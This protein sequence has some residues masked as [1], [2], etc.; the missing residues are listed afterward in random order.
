M[1]KRPKAAESEKTMSIMDHIAELRKRFVKSFLIFVIAMII[2]NVFYNPILDFVRHPLCISQINHCKLLL[3]SPLDGL[4]VRLKITSY[5]AI[6]LSFPF[7][8]YQILRFI[9]PGLT[10]N[11]KRYLFP[12]YA[13]VVIFFIMG[14]AVAYITY[15]HALTW[16]TDV[17][18]NNLYANYTADKYISLLLALMLIFGATFEFPVVLVGLELLRVISYTQLRKF[19]KYAFV[20]IVIAGGVLTPSSDPF[21]MF[22][23]VVPLYIFYELS[24]LAGR[25][26]VRPTKE[27]VSN[28]KSHK[29]QGMVNQSGNDDAESTD[30]NNKDSGISSAGTSINS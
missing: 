2:A 19:R 7:I 14:A 9:T 17:A 28:I 11:E 12:I 8:S 18:G 29:G 13:S 6:L 16:L 24:I 23:M 22:A 20:L 25:V 21:S 10:K 3:L 27:G 30:T 5:S 15:S 4:S 26:F 1:F